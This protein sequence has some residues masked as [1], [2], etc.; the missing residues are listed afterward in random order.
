MPWSRRQGPPLFLAVDQGD[1]KEVDPPSEIRRE[2]ERDRPGS[3]DASA[4]RGARRQAVWRLVHELITAGAK[5][6][7]QE[8]R[9]GTTALLY[10]IKSDRQSGGDRLSCWRRGADAG[11]RDNAGETPLLMACDVADTHSDGGS[12]GTWSR[13]QCAGSQRHDAA[14]AGGPRHGGWNAINATIWATRRSCAKTP[15][16]LLLQHGADVRLRDQQGWTALLYASE[17]EPSDSVEILLEHGAD[18]QYRCQ[19]PH[20][21]AECSVSRPDRE[22]TGAAGRRRQRRPERLFGCPDAGVPHRTRCGAVQFLLDHGADTNY[23]DQYGMTPLMLA[24]ANDHL[25]TA[26]S[27]GTSRSQCPYTRSAGQ[28]RA[29]LRPARTGRRDPYRGVRWICA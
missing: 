28:N 14:H 24:I 5:I 8:D 15:C 2:S 11:H 23:C 17:N 9:T 26:K 25:S 13:C 10:A 7:A 22:H 1:L 12:A 3:A 19:R 16:D 29:G 27:A 4:G 20:S 21:P 6:N 18:S